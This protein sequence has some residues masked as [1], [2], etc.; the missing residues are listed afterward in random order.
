VYL[1]HITNY[2]TECIYGTSQVTEPRVFTPATSQVTEPHVFTAHHKLQNSMYEYLRHIT[3]YRTA[4]IY[5]TSQ[6]TEPRVFTAHHNLQN[7]LYL[8][9]ITSYRTACIYGTSQAMRQRVLMAH[10]RLYN[11]VCGTSQW[12]VFTTPHYTT[13]SPSVVSPVSKFTDVLQA[14]HVLINTATPA[15]LH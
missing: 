6:V 10:H 4:C 9:H 2:R 3:S 1:R 15:L 13:T 12:Y 11:S 5:A 8:R 14:A 7:R